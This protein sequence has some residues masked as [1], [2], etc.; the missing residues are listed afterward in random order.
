MLKIAVSEVFGKKVLVIVE[1]DGIGSAFSP[2]GNARFKASNG[3]WLRSQTL[4]EPSDRGLF[5]RGTNRSADEKIIEVPKGEWLDL[6][7]VA[8]RE[9]NALDEKL[10]KD[11]IKISGKV[12]IIE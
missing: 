4:P 5:V 11:T 10:E 8:V 9:M 3:F 1:Q 7:R 12:E 6:L 2:R